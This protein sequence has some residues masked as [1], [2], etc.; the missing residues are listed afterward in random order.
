MTTLKK[1]LLVTSMLAGLAGCGPDG[2]SAGSDA[3]TCQA[4]DASQAAAE[5]VGGWRYAAQTTDC[6]C[7]DGSSFTMAAGSTQMETFSP[8]CD[9]N[10]VVTIDGNGCSLT[11]TVSGNTVSCD[12]GTCNVDG[13]DL[14]TTM[15][16]YTLVGGQ[17]HEQA[18]G[19]ATDPS[20]LKC[21][22]SSTD[23]V[24]TRIQ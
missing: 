13:T 16:V 1:I 5:F 14:N 6:S 19:I 2:G 20:G 8:T 7:A 23:G 15:D 12:P 21:Q 18:A 4:A 3:G 9:P 10:K 17:L 24:L 22:C 11:C